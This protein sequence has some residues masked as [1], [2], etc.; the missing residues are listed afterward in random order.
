M[1]RSSKN[2][3][4]A[5]YSVPGG[6]M[7]YC[8]IVNDDRPQ[9]Y[10]ATADHP[11]PCPTKI[12][13]LAGILYSPIITASFTLAAGLM[14][15]TVSAPV[16]LAIASDRQIVEPPPTSL[17]MQV[18]KLQLLPT[19]SENP[20]AGVLLAGAVLYAP[21][22]AIRRWPPVTFPEYATVE[23]STRELLCT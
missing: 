11:Q 9:A 4:I 23:L 17:K 20:P 10:A 16:L 21:Y 7:P 19:V 5:M 13:K 22:H 14:R 6:M 3:V 15:V 12:V 2:P 8:T 1:E 18:G